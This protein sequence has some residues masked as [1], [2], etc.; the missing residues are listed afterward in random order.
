M[1]VINEYEHNLETIARDIRNSQFVQVTVN[2]IF[3]LDIY[4][5]QSHQVVYAIYNNQPYKVNPQ[6]ILKT[7]LEIL[8]EK[9]DFT[10]EIDSYY[11]GMFTSEPLDMTLRE[12]KDIVD[13]FQFNILTAQ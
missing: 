9:D 10:I 11:S 12:I 13:V 5:N 7:F 4:Y 8:L 6:A 2:G 1:L 3:I